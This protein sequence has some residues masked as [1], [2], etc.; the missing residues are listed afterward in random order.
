MKVRAMT[1]ESYAISQNAG[2]LT[3]F[4]RFSTVEVVHVDGRGI[5]DFIKHKIARHRDDAR[6]TGAGVRE[7]RRMPLTVTGDGI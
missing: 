5:R 4:A 3:F 2:G 7:G 6:G 1:R